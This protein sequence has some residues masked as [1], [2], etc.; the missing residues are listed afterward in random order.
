MMEV[1]RSKGSHTI[2]H[3]EATKIRGKCYYKLSDIEEFLREWDK[4]RY[5]EIYTPDGKG[6]IEFLTKPNV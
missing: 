4:E 6:F 3:R 5:F 1:W 2:L